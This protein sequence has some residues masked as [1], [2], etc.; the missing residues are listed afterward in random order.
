MNLDPPT[1]ASPRANLLLVDD[2]AHQLDVFADILEAP[3]YR[4]VRADSAEDIEVATGLETVTVTVKR[5]GK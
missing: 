2:D 3:T 4:C 1:L 5:A